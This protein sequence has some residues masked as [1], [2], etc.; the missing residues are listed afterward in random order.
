MIVAMVAVRVMQMAI[1]QIADVVAVRH[2]LVSAAWSM[3]VVCGMTS[4]AMVRRATVGVGIGDL[5][6]VLVHMIAMHVMKVT[7]MQIISVIAVPDSDMPAPRTV[8]VGVTVM[9]GVGASAHGAVSSSAREYSPAGIRGTWSQVNILLQV[10]S[11]RAARR[12]QL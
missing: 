4:A 6:P 12:R 5:D 2:G 8:D 10:L 7:I 9:L 11:P 1:N 3:H